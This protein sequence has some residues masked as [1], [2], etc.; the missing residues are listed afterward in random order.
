MEKPALF[1]PCG[2]GNSERLHGMGVG[3]PLEGMKSHKAF[4]L[5]A[6]PAEVDR[7]GNTSL[8]SP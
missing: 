1:G 3:R 6:E 7:A 2:A 8:V 4:K 5:D